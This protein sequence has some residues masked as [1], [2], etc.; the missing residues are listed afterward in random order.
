M[1]LIYIQSAIANLSKYIYRGNIVELSAQDALM[2]KLKRSWSWSLRLGREEL[3]EVQ[4]GMYCIMNMRIIAGTN[5]VLK[6]QLI[7][8]SHTLNKSCV[9]CCDWIECSVLGDL[10][11]RQSSKAPLSSLKLQICPAGGNDTPASLNHNST[12]GLNNN[13]IHKHHDTHDAF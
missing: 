2:W 11:R 10:H 12:H 13:F 5:E 3:E 6:T 8:T 4:L 1:K 7:Y 9:I